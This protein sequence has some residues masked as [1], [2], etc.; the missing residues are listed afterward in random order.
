MTNRPAQAVNVITVFCVCDN[1][2]RWC[3]TT[4]MPTC[5]DSMVPCAGVGGDGLTRAAGLNVSVLNMLH[6]LHAFPHA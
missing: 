1:S 5:R 6:I 2:D 4:T 3:T